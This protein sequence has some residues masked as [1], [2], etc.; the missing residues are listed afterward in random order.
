M[1]KGYWPVASTAGGLAAARALINANE[2]EGLAAFA[3]KSTA[4][5]AGHPAIEDG[6]D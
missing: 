1:E 5:H 2:Q 6:P 4:V 3:R